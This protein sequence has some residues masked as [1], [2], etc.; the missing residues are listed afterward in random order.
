MGGTP[1][2]R[3]CHSK[4]ESKEEQRMI[5]K[6]TRFHF[7]I[8]MPAHSGW[9]CPRCNSVYAPW[10]SEC[11]HCKNNSVNISYSDTTEPIDI[12]KKV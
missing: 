3:E 11:L 7:G 1:L 5:N 4:T 8:S 2:C 6:E 10:V 12:N 9:I